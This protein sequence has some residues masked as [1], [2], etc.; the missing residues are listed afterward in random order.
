MKALAFRW[1]LRGQGRRCGKVC[2]QQEEQRIRGDV[3]IEIDQTVYQKPANRGDCARMERSREMTL[4]G[5]ERFSRLAE[6]Q[7]KKC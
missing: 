5:R 7:P 4:F 2:L 3:K 1:R 6:Q